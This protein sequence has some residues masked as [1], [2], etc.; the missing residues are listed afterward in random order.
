M[1]TTLV[2]IIAYKEL[3]HPIKDDEPVSSKNRSHL[4][5]RNNINKNLE[6]LHR[7][8]ASAEVQ[9]WGRALTAPAL[10][11]TTPHSLPIL[12]TT[13]IELRLGVVLGFL[14]VVDVKLSLVFRAK[15]RRF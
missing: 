12:S 8:E 6:Y 15:R 5:K 1:I 3:R 2:P 7:K 4:F 13:A 14:C 10:P 9:A 11:R